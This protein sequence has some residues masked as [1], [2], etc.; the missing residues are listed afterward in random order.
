MPS[1]VDTRFRDR[2]FP[3]IAAQFGELIVYTTGGTPTS[4]WALVIRGP[5]DDRGPESDA[6][7]EY[8]VEI[9]VSQADV[10]TPKMGADTVAVKRR[11]SDAAASTLRV[12][13]LLAEDSGTWRLRCE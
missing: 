3:R 5:L 9:V 1:P 8:G 2:A 12:T 13:A 7:Y 4:I 6:Y 11:L 10:A